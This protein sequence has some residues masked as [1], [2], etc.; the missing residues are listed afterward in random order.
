M[1]NFL[2]FIVMSTWSVFSC[3]RAVDELVFVGQDYP[4]YHW[5]DKNKAR[6]LFPE[7]IQT[8]CQKIKVK[9][10]FKIEPFKRGLM[11][12]ESGQNDAMMGLIHNTEREKFAKFTAPLAS[13][14][15]S[16][17]GMKTKVGEL[18]NI[19]DLD[20]ATVAVVRE[21][22][23]SKLAHQ[24]KNQLSSL[25]IV[26][27]SDNATILRMIFAGRF[28]R[29]AYILGNRDVI[30]HL[31]KKDG[32][33][34][35]TELL[36]VEDEEYSIAFSKKKVPDALFEKFNTALTALKHSK[37]IKGIYQKYGLSVAS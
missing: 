2:I 10:R 13:S 16:Y 8:T 7:V 21:S 6:G 12:I 37:S 5:Q 34:S 33:E 36:F 14:A 19:K 35:I 28:G 22:S 23:S 17:F 27:Q 4:P 3:A 15:K 25:K 24:H 29:Q 1:K 18:K 20:G 9:C 32:Y 30:F 31:I 11:E 26:E